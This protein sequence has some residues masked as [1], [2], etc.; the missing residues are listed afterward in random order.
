MDSQFLHGAVIGGLAAEKQKDQAGKNNHSGGVHG[1][2][3]LLQVMDDFETI[4]MEGEN[5]FNV[6][7]TVDGW[8]V[9]AC[10]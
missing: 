10:G 3:Y 4:V 5:L 9:A 7:N 8:Q 1:H 6:K 2:G